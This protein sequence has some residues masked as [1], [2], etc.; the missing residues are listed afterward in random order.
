MQ[1]LKQNKQQ[2]TKQAQQKLQELQNKLITKD[3]LLGLMTILKNS[4]DSFNQKCSNVEFMNDWCMYRHLRAIGVPRSS[5]KSW[6]SLF[7]RKK[8]ATLGLVIDILE[9]YIP[10]RLTEENF[11]LFMETLAQPENPFFAHKA[12]L[13]FIVAMRDIS[14]PEEWEEVLSVCETIRSLKEGCLPS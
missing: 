2:M 14:N 4:V 3:Q 1:Q 8:L 7:R 6:F 5:E 9:P 12:R 13:D 10:F 11:E